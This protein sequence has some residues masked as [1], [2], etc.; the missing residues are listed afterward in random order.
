MS[1]LPFIS[2]LVI[3]SY[4]AFFN[5]QV[6]Q[7]STTMIFFMGI[8]CFF[9][10]SMS[11]ASTTIVSVAC[12][13]FFGWNA[14]PILL[15]MFTLGTWFGYAISNWFDKNTIMGFIKMNPEMYKFVKKLQKNERLML[16]TMRL[17]PSLPFAVTNFFCSYIEIPL[18]KYLVFGT[19]GIALRLVATVW[20]G[21]QIQSFNEDIENDP[22]Y[23]LQKYVFIGVAL[24]LFSALYYYV[25][26][27]K[28]EVE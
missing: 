13:Y 2:T 17:T 3:I 23:Q 18:K 15:G 26:R 14:Y 7:W 4:S 5:E 1:I 28:D 25:M 22:T 24:V 8:L 6:S 12:G 9:L 21:T 27:E 19:I 11:L 20:V 10:T 16:F